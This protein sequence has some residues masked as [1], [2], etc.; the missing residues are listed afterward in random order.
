MLLPLPD[1]PR[2]HQ[3]CVQRATSVLNC[4]RGGRRWRCITLEVKAAREGTEVRLLIG[5]AMA[6]GLNG[7]DEGPVTP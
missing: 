4:A 5:L 1:L 3:W 6:A 2:C 7:C